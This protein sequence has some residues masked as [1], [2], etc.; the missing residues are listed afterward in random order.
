[1]KRRYNF[2]Y[3]L[4]ASVFLFLLSGCFRYSTQKGKASYYADYYEG[5]KT[6][7]GEIYRQNRITAAHKTLPFD[8]KV[9]VTNLS[10]NK[11]IIVRINDRGPYVKGRIIDL[12][13]AAAKEIGMIGAG[14]EKVKI[15][16]RRKN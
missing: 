13:K 5:R 11:S 14:V 10:N 1:M 8:T 16:Y 4:S 12:T 2:Y 15:R 9:L 3:F 6:A 7:N